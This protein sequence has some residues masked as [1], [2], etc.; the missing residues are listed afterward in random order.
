MV[1]NLDKKKNSKPRWSYF[2]RNLQRIRP[3]R[4]H[5]TPPNEGKRA[6]TDN[7]LKSDE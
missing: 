2:I 6:N 3:I 5:Q 4:K 7:I 1:I